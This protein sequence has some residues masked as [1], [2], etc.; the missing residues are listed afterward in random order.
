[1]DMDNYAQQALDMYYKVPGAP[2]LR[3]NV[4]YPWY[5]PTL[6]EIQ[7]VN[8]A[9]IKTIFG[10]CAASLLMKLLY[11]AR[12]VRLDICY[13]INCLSRYVTRWNTL[14]DK[15]LS[16][17]F[18]Y[19]LQSKV[20]KLHA[21]IDTMESETVEL[22]AYPDADLAGSYDST[23]ATSGGFIHLQGVN[24]FFQLDWYPNDKL[25]QPIAQRR[26]S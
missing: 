26:P 1:M 23:R 16:H 11:A 24:T 22:H 4:C 5:E 7:E 8:E 6:P 21:T 17:L 14:C 12:M 19:L 10:H 9:G 25:Q 3:A 18:A 13:S 2:P 15:Q 20:S